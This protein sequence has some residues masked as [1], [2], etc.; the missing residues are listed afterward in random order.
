VYVNIVEDMFNGPPLLSLRG[1]IAW[2]TL[3]IVF[4]LVGFVIAAA[5]P[6]V[7]TLSGMGRSFYLPGFDFLL[8]RQL[9]SEP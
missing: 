6:Q 7:Q 3:V 9:K 5:I 1:R 4:W 2:T 8:T